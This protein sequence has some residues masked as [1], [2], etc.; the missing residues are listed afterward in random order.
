MG[1]RLSNLEALL[2]AGAVASAVVGPGD[3][4]AV[5]TAVPEI[6][7]AVRRL[8]ERVRTGELAPAGS[9]AEASGGSTGGARVSWL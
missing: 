4:G 2:E 3:A 5:R 8:L 7:D 6:L 1:G 9:V